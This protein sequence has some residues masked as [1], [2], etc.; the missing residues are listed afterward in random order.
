MIHIN[1]QPCFFTKTMHNINSLFFS[2]PSLSS[3]CL[4]EQLLILT[5]LCNAQT[6]ILFV[7]CFLFSCF[8]WLSWNNKEL[9]LQSNCFLSNK[10]YTHLL[11]NNDN[12]FKLKLRYCKILWCISILRKNEKCYQLKKWKMLT[13]VWK[14]LKRIISH[15]LS[16]NFCCTQLW[17]YVF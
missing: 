8:I 11:D 2:S 10:Q 13:V 5:P 12:K 15:C 4:R 9:S 16:N 17:H 14:M 7:L 3:S 1:Y 6:S